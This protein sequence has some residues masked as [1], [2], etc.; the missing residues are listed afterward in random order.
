MTPKVKVII[1]NW[2]QPQLTI[3]C[4][5]S[6][7]KSRYDN[8]EI[9][10]IDNGSD[11]NSI[12]LLKKEFPNIEILSL[13]KNYKFAGAYNRA[14]DYISN[15]EIDYLLLLNNDTIVDSDLVQNFIKCI[16]CNPNSILG[17]KI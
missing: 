17:A 3:D 7:D 5:K 2:N 6:V 10:V 11:D 4:I 1:L 15:Q 16:K 9:L 12:N 14:I 8:F 13:N